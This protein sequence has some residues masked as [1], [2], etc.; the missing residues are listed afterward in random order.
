MHFPSA[1]AVS[2]SPTYASRAV[3]RAHPFL[4]SASRTSALR[5]P[6]EVSLP[7]PTLSSSLVAR[8]VSPILRLILAAVSLSSGSPE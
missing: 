2:A 7:G 5:A 3:S 8:S 6:T 1:A 4:P